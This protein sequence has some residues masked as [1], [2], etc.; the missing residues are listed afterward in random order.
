VPV[1]KPTPIKIIGACSEYI[2]DTFGFQ[3]EKKKGKP[4][5]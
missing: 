4:N 1:L 2:T 5:S 3:G